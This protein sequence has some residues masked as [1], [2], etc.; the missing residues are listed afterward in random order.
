M[1][2]Y[3]AC[4]LAIIRVNIRVCFCFEFICPLKLR[5]SAQPISKQNHGAV[6]VYCTFKEPKELIPRNRFQGS[7]LYKFGLSCTVVPAFTLGLEFR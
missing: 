1:S 6:F 7:N 2:G 4:S 5:W 3:L